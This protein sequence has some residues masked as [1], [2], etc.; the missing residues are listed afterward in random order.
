MTSLEQHGLIYSLCKSNAFSVIK[1][2]LAMVETQFH[3]HV[4]TTRTDNALELGLSREATEFF[5][6]KDFTVND[7]DTRN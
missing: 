2:F 4:Q 1:Y 5:L 7:G 3:S 6:S